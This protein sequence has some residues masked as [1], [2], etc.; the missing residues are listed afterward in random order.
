M[1]KRRRIKMIQTILAF[2]LAII[3]FFV[4]GMSDVFAWTATNI[5]TKNGIHV[6]LSNKVARQYENY[7]KYPFH[8]IQWDDLDQFFSKLAEAYGL[9]DADSTKLKV[10]ILSFDEEWVDNELPVNADGTIGREMIYGRYGHI[11]GIYPS[12]F[13]IVIHLGDDTGRGNLSF[14]QTALDWELWHYFERLKGDPC[15]RDEFNPECQAKFVSAWSIG[16]CE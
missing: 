15:W 13:T 3:S 11:D 5:F 2:I 4:L 12:N 10:K 6:I 7:W 8:E 16:L 1:F 14:C 9:P